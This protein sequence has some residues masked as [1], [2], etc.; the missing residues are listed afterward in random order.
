MLLAFSIILSTWHFPQACVCLVSVSALWA[1][2]KG[3]A[4]VPGDFEQ[5]ISTTLREVCKAGFISTKAPHMLTFRRYIIFGGGLFAAFL[6]DSKAKG[7]MTLLPIQL[8]PPSAASELF[9]WKPSSPCDLLSFI[10]LVSCLASF[11]VTFWD[12]SSWQVHQTSCP[13]SSVSLRV[14]AIA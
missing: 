1:F 9:W 8:L 10:L 12:R 2:V 3:L 11:T 13:F 4:E 5:I 7:S 14:Q 6:Q